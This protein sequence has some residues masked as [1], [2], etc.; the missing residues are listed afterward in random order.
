MHSTTSSETNKSTSELLLL[1]AQQIAVSGFPFVSYLAIS[2]RF[3][4]SILGEFSQALA[5][6]YLAQPVLVYSFDVNY[7]QAVNNKNIGVLTLSALSYRLFI[8]V[9]SLC[10]LL[11]IA[12]TLS[13]IPLGASLVACILSLELVSIS[14]QQTW[15]HNA[16]SMNLE[17]TLTLISAR[18]ISLALYFTISSEETSRLL[19]ELAIA[20]AF[21]SL[22]AS[23]V[24]FLNTKLQLKIKIRSISM[25]AVINETLTELKNGCYLFA[26]NMQVFLIKDT[27]P[28]ILGFLDIAPSLIGTYALAEKT[29]QGFVTLSRPWRILLSKRFSTQWN[30]VI[31]HDYRAKRKLVNSFYANMTLIGVVFSLLS[32]LVSRVALCEFHLSCTTQ[33]SLI[34]S[35]S[36]G[37]SVANGFWCGAPSRLLHSQSYFF[38]FSVLSSVVYISIILLQLIGAISVSISWVAIGYLLSEITL[39]LLIYIFLLL[40][41]PRSSL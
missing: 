37:V 30:S 5:F 29:V 24:L 15:L 20:W 33:I 7:F 36:L 16:L 1:Y 6:A 12:P 40:P 41:T 19:L 17:P 23:T 13:L 28:M 2:F 11:F 27:S 35:C 38:F 39:Y 8:A 4:S 22:T 31:H 9:S 26:M 14:F 18:L 21:P 10:I 3:G 25:H 32:Y 34:L